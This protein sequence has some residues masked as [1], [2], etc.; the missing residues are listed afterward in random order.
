[1]KY[2]CIRKCY[3]GEKL[4]LEGDIFESK[5]DENIP[6]HFEKIETDKEDVKEDTKAITKE[7]ETKV[8]TEEEE[9]ERLRAECDR[10]GKPYDG[11]W[12]KFKLEQVIVL[13]K[14]GL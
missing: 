2:R 13:A 5:T 9:I 1:M 6:R 7:E 10:L 8:L 11:R 12:G 4:W 14:K 3:Y